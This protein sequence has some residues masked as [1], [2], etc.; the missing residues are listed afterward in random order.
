MKQ[1]TI[2]STRM[3][4]YRDAGFELTDSDITR[5]A[6]RAE[7]ENE[8]SPHAFIYSRYRNPTV[9]E[10]EEMIMQIEGSKWALLT[11]SGMSA[12]DTALSVFQEAA[13]TRPWL[14]FS[15]IY[16]GTISYIDSVLIERRGLEIERFYPAGMIWDTAALEKI[17]KSVKPSLVFFETVSN[18]M[19]IVAP[20]KEIIELIHSNGA[21]AIIDNTFATADLVKPLALGADIVIHSATKYLG[22]HGNITA[23][24]LCGNSPELMKQAIEYRKYTGH[25]LSPD[26]AY[27]LTTQMQS[28]SLRFRRQC[29]NAFALAG[30]LDKSKLIERVYYP[31]LKSHATY[32]TAKELFGGKGYGAIVTFDF[33]GHDDGE[34][35]KRRDAFI[36]AVSGYVK[37]VPTLGDSHTILMPVEPIWGD[38]YPEPGMIR[39]STGFEDTGELVSAIRAS[40][41]ETG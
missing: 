8:H 9:I 14:F 20:M 2:N 40:L 1:K 30:E 26:D 25:M 36:G 23:G 29:D 32:S 6:F 12:I 34:K 37:L 28:F 16:G 7:A 15:E 19:L 10:A 27:R 33:A 41:E 17:L 38:R 31:G 21:V 4:V 35:R 22:G 13:D 18:P 39:L 11:Q 3:P 24:V 5:E